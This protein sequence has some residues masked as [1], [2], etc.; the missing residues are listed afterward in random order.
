MFFLCPTVQ[1]LQDNHQ[2]LKWSVFLYINMFATIILKKRFI[3]RS[4]DVWLLYHFLI[5][6]FALPCHEK[7]LLELYWWFLKWSRKY[8]QESMYYIL[9]KSKIFKCRNI[10][11]KVSWPSTICRIFSSK[12]EV[13]LRRVNFTLDFSSR[14][15]DY[16]ISIELLNKTKQTFFD[17]NTTS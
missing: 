5:I 13:K 3:E 15:F 4:F 12:K 8:I 10:E 14:R 17:H 7:I 1:E 16:I 9:W 2:P 6:N 11:R